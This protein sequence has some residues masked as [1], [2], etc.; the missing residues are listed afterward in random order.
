MPAEYLQGRGFVVTVI[1]T[2]RQ[3]SARLQVDDGTV[4]IIVP[5]ELPTE[6]IQKIIDEKTRWVKEK[7]Y[8]HSQSMPVSNKEFV[9]GEAFPYLGRNYRLKL[10]AGNWQPVKLKYGRLLLTLPIESCTSEQIRDALIRWYRYQ[11]EQ[12]FAE[13][14]RRYAK[15]I[16]VTPSSV[17]VKTFKSRW[18]SCSVK[19]EILFHWKVI[20]APHRIVDYVV[21]HELCHLKHHD[22][23]PAFWKSVES[24][25]P[26]YMECKEWLKVMGA[27]LEI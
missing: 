11:A 16:G 26:D 24:V 5:R 9:S 7:L 21:V 10:E 14:V 23:S 27:G 25:I 1:R 2:Q 3:K 17:G 13:K 15:I 19:G 6:R 18:G 20:L 22:H 4:E 8:L 12:R